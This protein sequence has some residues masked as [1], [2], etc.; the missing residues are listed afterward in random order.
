MSRE[1]LS[2]LALRRRAGR[3]EGV[4]SVCS[5]HRWVIAAALSEA[6]RGFVLIEATCN[7]VNQDGGY[8]RMTPFDFRR[9]VESIAEKIGFDASRIVLGGDHLGPNPWKTLPAEIAMDKAETLVA[10]YVEAGFF[11]IHLDASMGC[12]GE[13]A[14]LDDDVV[15]ER[16][17]RLAARAEMVAAARGLDPPI[18]VIGTEVPSPGGASRTN[19]RIELT[20]PESA[21]RTLAAHRQAFTRRG[22]SAALDRLI[23]LVVQPGVEFDNERVIT[24]RTQEAKPLASVLESEPGIVFEAH[25]TDY[26]RTDVLR[27]LVDQGFAILKVGPALT[28]ALR[29]ALYGLDRIAC[30]L[31]P[32]WDGR[33]L[34]SEMERIMTQEPG[35]WAG[36][37]DGDNN[38]QRIQRHYSYS[39]RIR[40]YWSHPQAKTATE[41]LLEALGSVELPETLVMEFLPRS[42]ETV[43]D[44]AVRAL[45]RL[46]VDLAIRQELSRYRGATA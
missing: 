33:T 38:H 9:F 34:R 15:A 20:S 14:A 4:T 16:A 13:A 30:E 11:K 2:G 44:G 27:C 12:R 28:F 31:I 29:E 18:Y 40:Y 22:I 24:Y 32:D 23:A 3:R 35:H 19:S 17:S 39:D 41:R 25:S 46:L 6:G 45:P 42:Y 43:R 37:Y 36:Y 5:A 10:S 21:R 26:Q 8:T 7:Q 1:W